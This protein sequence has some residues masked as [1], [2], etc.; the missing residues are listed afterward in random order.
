MKERMYQTL[1][2]LE[3]QTNHESYQAQKPSVKK[4]L[5][6][7]KVLIIIFVAMFLSMYLVTNAQLLRD[8]IQ[9]SFSP[10]QVAKI[11]NEATHASAK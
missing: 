10:Q 5:G 3:W 1:D 2:D 6:E 9:D 8:R 11:D 7:A 4:F